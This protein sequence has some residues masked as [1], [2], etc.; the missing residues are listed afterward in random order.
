MATKKTASRSL[1]KITTKDI[2]SLSGYRGDELRKANDAIGFRVSEGTLTFLARKVFNVMLL[3]AQEAKLPGKNAPFESA[4]SDKYYWIRMSELVKDAHY[5]SNDSD[6]LK[7]TLESMQDIKIVRE[8]SRQWTSERLVSSVTIYSTKGLNSHAGQLWVG[9][10]FPP[11]VQEQVLNP[12]TYTSIDLGIQASL[13]SGSSIALYEIC[14]RYATNPSK[15]TS[16]S[17]V[18]FWH[19]QLSS[20]PKPVF[21]GYKYFKRDILKPS[22]SEVNAVTDIFI[23]MIEYKNGRRIESLQFKVTPN[24]QY[25]I[26]FP[27]EPVIDNEYINSLMKFGF[28]RADSADMTAK[29]PMDALHIAIERMRARQNDSSLSPLSSPVGYFRWIIKSVMADR[30]SPAVKTTVKKI[31]PTSTSSSPSTGKTSVMDKFLLVRAEEAM[32]IY[33]EMKDEE[34]AELL[35]QFRAQNQNSIIKFSKSM[36]GN[37]LLKTAFSMWYAEILWGKPSADDLARFMERYHVDS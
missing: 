11:E 22:I 23:E 2:R 31:A 36:D 21:P 13:R 3:R 29:Y 5:G 12:G 7:K 16:I 32:V 9:F 8:T 30:L 24:K 26:E 18:E 14:R 1:A 27:P 17:P 35:A 15:L 25:P 28:S 10:A 19:A 37:P 6:T 20:G 4:T 34:Q 33:R